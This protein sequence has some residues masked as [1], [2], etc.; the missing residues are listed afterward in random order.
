MERRPPGR[1]D[2]I[3]K[4]REVYCMNVFI[5][6]IELSEKQLLE[7]LGQG[8]ATEGMTSFACDAVSGGHNKKVYE[9]LEIMELPK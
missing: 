1:L 7:A 3:V 4:F 9:D 5:L 8:L 2:E 6:K